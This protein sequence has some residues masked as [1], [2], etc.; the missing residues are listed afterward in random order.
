MPYLLIKKIK[1]LSLLLFFCCLK[2]AAQSFYVSAVDYT[3][4]DGD[5][6]YGTNLYRVTIGP[7]NTVTSQLIT[8]CTP[9]NFFSIAMNGNTLY[10]VD[11]GYL[12]KANIVGNELE[13]CA[14]LGSLPIYSNALTAGADGKVYYTGQYLYS[15][16]PATMQ[17]STLGN[18]YYSASGD[19]TFYN[20][21]LYMASSGI[22]KIDTKNAAESY[23]YM[24]VAGNLSLYGLVSVATSLHKNTVY[25]L[26]YIN[27]NRTDI[28]EFDLDNK[29]V[30]GVIG[31]LPYSVLDAASPVENGSI[32]GI[33]INKINIHQDCDLGTK[34][35]VEVITTPSLNP[36]TYK[37]TNG[38]TTFTNTTGVFASLAAGTYQLTV[39]SSIDQQ[40]AQVVVPVYNLNKPTYSYTIKNQVCDQ[41]GEITFKTA[42]A[43][44]TY[45]VRLGSDVFPINHTFTGLVSGA[46]YHFDILN[47]YGCKVDGVDINVPKDKCTIK[48]NKVNVNQQCDVI[49]KGV[50]Q[51]VTNAHYDQ[52][53]YT[54]NGVSNTTGTFSN[55]VA[56]NYT[57]KITSP[58][59]AISVPA[60]VPDYKLTQPAI[61]Y[62]AT[63]PACAAKGSIK[64][65]IPGSSTGYTIKYGAD[66]Y[67]FNHVFDGLSAGTYSFIVADP[68]GC[69]IDQYNVELKYQPCPIVINS[70]NF[71]AEC[72]AFGQAQVQVITPPIPETYSYT[73]NGVN[74]NTG[75]FNLVNP[76]TYNLLVTASGGGTPQNRTVTVPDF[77]LNR[78]L[79]VVK[80]ISPVCE[81][82]GQISMAVGTN[83]KLYNVS[84][85]NSVYP[86][87][88]VFKDLAAGTY[89]FIIL[90]KDG[91]IADIIDVD[92]VLEVCSPVS[93][94]SAFTPNQD[95]VNDIFEADPKSK[96][97]N[98]KLQIYNRW[99][100]MVFTSTDLHAG[101]DGRHNGGT[102]PVGTYY[103]VATFTNQENKPAMQKGYVTLIR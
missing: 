49:H 95:G 70:V 83:S 1:L 26:S 8:P 11:D 54:L 97:T 41:Q 30:K 7:G 92:L 29:V 77:K 78:P 53:T 102:C 80:T 45:L 33:V 62:L 85:N 15:T 87:D 13:N 75:V 96:A 39:T 61:G 23:V 40:I 51:V 35:I 36:L 73:L 94:P 58:E 22:V 17:T 47:E 48:F 98:F 2:A 44:N 64:F 84:Y 25:G 57:I 12:L 67:P 3:Y 52:Y 99:G 68:N 28:V 24:P 86:S 76:G 79:T 27:Q 42:D 5:A 16:D 82:L 18:M 10:W 14:T 69:L 81:L 101:W 20:G 71:T 21:D 55:L 60:V 38:A 43:G 66:T 19:V 32:N 65:S 74:N 90:K 50:I 46:P 89:E 6:F 37:L 4:V 56:G 63:D 72:Y 9:S 34:G 100:Q 103:W 59:D 88:H 31:T 91:C 93:F